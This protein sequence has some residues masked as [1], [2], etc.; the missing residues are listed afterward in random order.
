MNNNNNNNNVQIAAKETSNHEK[1]REKEK[2]KKADMKI[3][4]NPGSNKAKKPTDEAKKPPVNIDDL[5]SYAEKIK[6]INFENVKLKKRKKKHA[7]NNEEYNID[8]SKNPKNALIPPEEA[9]ISTNLHTDEFKHKASFNEVSHIF[10][11]KN[12]L[13][14]TSCE[15][16]D[17]FLKNLDSNNENIVGIESHASRKHTIQTT[18]TERTKG[19]TESFNELMFA[20]NT[21]D[22]Q[23]EKREL[24]L[25]KSN[26]YSIQTLDVAREK[27]RAFKL[28]LNS[29]LKEIGCGEI[30]DKT[31]HE[32]K[33]LIQDFTTNRY[34]ISQNDRSLLV[35]LQELVLE[36]KAE[37]QR[38]FSA[39]TQKL[40]SGTM[41]ALASNK[42]K[43]EVIEEKNEDFEC[44]REGK[45][46][47]LKLKNQI[48]P[49]HFS[50]VNTN[51]AENIGKVTG[52]QKNP[53]FGKKERTKSKEKLYADIQ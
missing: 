38:C 28:Q 33:S 36:E 46:P 7:K 26:K 32:V 12:H 25:E 39:N 37:K 13:E 47:G 11:E 18:N 34:I 48:N 15:N 5:K 27:V 4:K 21:F 10:Q 17:E 23:S 42:L 41:N 9:K 35:K 31:K 3:L 2:D 22:N 53:G 44:D 43:Q 8:S 14:E 40:I 45:N 16:F 30:S 19:I 1:E 6:N 50:K 49:G 20:K 29:L 24:S 52:Q 51:Y